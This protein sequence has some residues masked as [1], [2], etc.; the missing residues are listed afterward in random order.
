MTLGVSEADDQLQIDGHSAAAHSLRLPGKRLFL[1][2]LLKAKKF[3]NYGNKQGALGAWKEL[4]ESGIGQ[5]EQKEIKG[6]GTVS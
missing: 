5:I 1:T 6:S 4:Q 3:R 2:P